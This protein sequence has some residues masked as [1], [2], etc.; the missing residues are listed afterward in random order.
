MAFTLYLDDE[1][2][3]AKMYH[4]Y[5]KQVGGSGNLTFTTEK[6]GASSLAVSVGTKVILIYV[7][8]D[9]NVYSA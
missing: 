6:E 5:L 2:T 4:V 9:G 1:N 7:D 3:G 8:S